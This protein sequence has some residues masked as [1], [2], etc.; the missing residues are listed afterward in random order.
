MNFYIWKLDK[1]E[2]ITRTYELCSGE[3]KQ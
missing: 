3:S 2:S 1:K